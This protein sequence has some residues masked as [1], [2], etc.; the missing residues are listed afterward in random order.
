MN[1]DRIMEM[2]AQL[3]QGQTELKL[4]IGDM[5][6]NMVRLENKFDQKISSLYEFMDVQR[7]TNLEFIKRFDRIDAKIETLLI[8]TAHVRRVK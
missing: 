8:E 3:L 4:D 1:D 6:L 5:K 7:K 2:F